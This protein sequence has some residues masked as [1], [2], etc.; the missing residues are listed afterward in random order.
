[1]VAVEEGASSSSR[2]SL[3]TGR[4]A[5]EFGTTTSFL[6]CST[7]AGAVSKAAYLIDANSCRKVRPIG[8]GVGKND[9]LY[10]KQIDN[11]KMMELTPLQ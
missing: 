9:L 7:Q 8:I 3:A 10:A 1:M 2:T 5:S 11:N 6:V 4:S